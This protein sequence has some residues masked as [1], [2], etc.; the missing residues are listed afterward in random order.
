[1]LQD[2]CLKELQ[3]FDREVV[4]P[5]FDAQ[6]LREQIALERFNTPAMFQTNE[7]ADREVSSLLCLYVRNGSLTPVQRQQKIMQVLDG[8]AVP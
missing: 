7:T 5:A 1:M 2:A 8:L 4:L 6:V 3:K